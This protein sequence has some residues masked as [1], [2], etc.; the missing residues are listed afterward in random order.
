MCKPPPPPPAK[1]RVPRIRTRT[2]LYT[3]YLDVPR[4]RSRARS[5]LSARPVSPCPA[6]RQEMGAGSIKKRT[7]PAGLARR[8]SCTA[9]PA[10][11][12][13]PQPRWIPSLQRAAVLYLPH[14]T[15]ELA[16]QF[17]LNHAL[18]QPQ[19]QPHPHRCSTKTK[20]ADRRRIANS[21][22]KSS[23]VV[24]GVGPGLTVPHRVKHVST[25]ACVRMFGARGLRRH[26]AGWALGG[27]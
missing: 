24:A 26:G 11:R 12:V 9:S 3:G 20:A 7:C 6:S 25:P 22:P 16:L 17:T 19:P 1:A 2:V 5:R 10:F 18:P 21:M 15:T 4:A 27:R 13:W 14:Q 23:A 8:P